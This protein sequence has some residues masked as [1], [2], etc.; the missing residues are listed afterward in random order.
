MSP[1][2]SFHPD[3]LDVQ[4][5]IA[6]SLALS[7]L[8]AR[9]LV[10]RGIRSVQEA[11]TF[12]KPSLS[13]LS[14][15]YRMVHM[16]AAV[17]RILA[18]LK[19]RERILVYGD[20][21]VDG[22]AG[23]ALLAGFLSAAGGEV[24]T[25]IPDRLEEGYSLTDKGVGSILERGADVV[26][27]VDNGTTAV[28]QV[29]GLRARGVD[30]IVT[31]HHEP[32]EELPAATALLN[33]KVPGC[34]YP[35]PHLCGTAVGFQVLSALAARLPA[36][37][38]AREATHDLLRHCLALVGLATICDCVPLIGE[39]RILARAGLT[40]LQETEHPGLRA[41]LQEAEVPREVQADD[42]SFR[43][44]PRINAAGRLGDAGEALA[45]LLAKDAERGRELARLLSA[46]NAERQEIEARILGDARR[47]ASA[48]LRQHDP[49]IVLADDHWHA[50]V[51]GIV[52]ARLAAEF[53]RPAVLIAMGGERGRGSG[54][55]VPG[56]D[57]YQAL[58][59]CAG[60][61]LAFGGHA[62][63]AGV[64]IERGAFASFK[65]ALLAAA[66]GTSAGA[67]AREI[68]IDA[69]VPLGVLDPS[70]MSEINRLAP[71][72]EG[73]PAPVFAAARLTLDGEARLVG[74]NKNHLSFAVRQSNV[75]R[76]AI[77]YDMGGLAGELRRSSSFSLAFIPRLNLF[78]GRADVE[79]EVKD[80]HL[81]EAAT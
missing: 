35:F 61:L 3:R 14:D 11:S 63:A 16:E 49:V 53:N 37:A 52:A 2:W 6:G 66:R 32:A 54:R 24:S 77:A 67:A 38:A 15:P 60:H 81:P 39:N 13:L 58:S 64:E 80:I 1:R 40:A 59:C 42:V 51:V 78:R 23:T 9:L 17:E 29:A 19:N 8:A 75:R 18:A 7:S 70:L 33:P 50:G 34:G 36:R 31:D 55:S 44:G 62:R 74:K 45:L 28:S 21:D 26:I 65:E 25:Y 48:L 47:Q 57:L 79:M 4:E 68:M 73:M 22:V 20:S 12:L 72:G 76:K 69:E 71:F 56:F 43:L 46:R 30:V 10:N 41:L 5:R 27:T